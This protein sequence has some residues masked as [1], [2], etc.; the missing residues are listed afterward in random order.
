MAESEVR[1]H[2]APILAADA[3]GYMRLMKD[4]TKHAHD[5]LGPVHDWFMERF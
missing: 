3:I 5:V 2:L 4:D 1:R